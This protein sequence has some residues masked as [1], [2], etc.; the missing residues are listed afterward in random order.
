VS[1]EVVDALVKMVANGRKFGVADTAVIDHLVGLGVPKEHAEQLRA[2]IATSL[3]AGHDSAAAG[4][5]PAELPTSP[6]AL[7]AFNAGRRAFRE[8]EEQRGRPRQTL[9]GVLVFLV[10]GALVV[11]VVTWW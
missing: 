9:I 10:L 6:L 7:A 11:A 3:Q 5:E 2:E 1:P 4:G 8:A